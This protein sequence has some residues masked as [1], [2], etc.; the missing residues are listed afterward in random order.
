M[1]ECSI[2]LD[3]I[4]F[5]YKT[6]CNHL[7]HKKCIITWLENNNTCPFCRNVIEH[8][9]NIDSYLKYKIM[10]IVLYFIYLCYIPFYILIIDKTLYGCLSMIITYCSSVY[11]IFINI[12]FIL[13]YL[14]NLYLKYTNKFLIIGFLLG[15]SIIILNYII[16]V[17]S[18]LAVVIN[19]IRMFKNIIEYCVI[20]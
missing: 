8:P 14:E 18:I 11:I 1:N 15:Y 12:N 20:H 3:K 6:E 13:N 19:T 10:L 2:C 9:K 7:F 16:V 4:Y 17:E 5:R